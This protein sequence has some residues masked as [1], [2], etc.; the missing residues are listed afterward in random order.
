M[1]RLAATGEHDASR[2][3]LDAIR[4]AF[5]VDKEDRFLA[6]NGVLNFETR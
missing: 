1:R 2:G 5:P 3:Y 6:W 4:L